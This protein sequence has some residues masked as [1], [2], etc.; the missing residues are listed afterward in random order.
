[1]PH[2][3]KRDTHQKGHDIYLVIVL[4]PEAAKT[5]IIICRE[6]CVESSLR[7]HRGLV[8]RHPQIAKSMVLKSLT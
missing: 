1:M 3:N 5:H 2:C 7:I 8:L 4:S 6:E